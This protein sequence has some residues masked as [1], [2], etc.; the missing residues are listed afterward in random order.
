MHRNVRNIAA[1][2]AAAAAKPPI[3]IKCIIKIAKCHTTH[4]LTMAM[5]VYIECEGA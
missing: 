1:A 3:N 5:N 2:A 4:E